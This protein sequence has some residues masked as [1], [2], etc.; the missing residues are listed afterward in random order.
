MG[1]P[2][3]RMGAET[4]P[5]GPPDPLAAVA[6]YYGERLRRFGAT[7]P[8]VDWPN[9][10]NQELRFIPLL[11]V[12]DFAQPC[13]LNDVGCGYGALR[14]L[15]SRRQRGA[16]IDYVGTDVS[17]AM[18]A[19]ARRRWRHR[20]DCRFEQA[21][22]AVRVADWSLASGLFNVKLDCPLPDW[23]AL[24]AR[25]LANLQRHSRR[26]YAVNFVLPPAPGQASPAQLYRPPP[27]RWLAHLARHQPGCQVTLLRGY[28]LPEFTLL[29][30]TGTLKLKEFVSSKNQT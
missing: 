22:G 11:K 30:R 5:G 8:G 26:G 25:T 10:P 6:R 19:A 14:A 1:A 21:D 20:A 24:V 27:E 17:L 12:C 18:V 9:R 28:G 29:V 7:A 2:P 4:R 23:E 13:S 15:L 3:K 16:R